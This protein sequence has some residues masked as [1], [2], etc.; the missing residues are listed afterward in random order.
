MC[1]QRFSIWIFKCS[2]TKRKVYKHSVNLVPTQVFMLTKKNSGCNKDLHAHIKSLE[3]K[4]LTMNCFF[5]A[6]L[7]YNSIIEGILQNWLILKKGLTSYI[8]TCP[9]PGIPPPSR[10]SLSIFLEKQKQRKN[11]PKLEMFT[12]LLSI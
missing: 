11:V 2:D 6:A 12:K 9:S 1:L 8:L 3:S 7:K 5:N 10:R 4:I